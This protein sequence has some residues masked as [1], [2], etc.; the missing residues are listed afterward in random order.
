MEGRDSHMR[1]LIDLGKAA[2]TIKT[3]QLP[4]SSLLDPARMHKEIEQPRTFGRLDLKTTEE[5][6]SIQ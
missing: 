2:T 5:S 3:F 1:R 6:V 4:T